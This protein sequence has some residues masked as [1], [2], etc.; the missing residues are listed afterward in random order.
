MA[1]MNGIL[2][3]QVIGCGAYLPSRVVTNQELAQRVD[4]QAATARD[5]QLER[6]PELE[7]DIGQQ[8]AREGGDVREV[9]AHGRLERFA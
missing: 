7:R 4:E 8:L 1:Y 3:S 5:E 9:L 2:R 6:R